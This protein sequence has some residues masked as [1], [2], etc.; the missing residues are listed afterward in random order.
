MNSSLVFAVFML[1]ISPIILVLT[2]I[3]R[4]AGKTPILNFID[5]TSVQNPLELHRRVG[6][7]LILLPV[8]SAVFGAL[9]L[10]M[11]EFAVSTTIV[12]IVLSFGLVW[13]AVLSAQR[14]TDKATKLPSD[15]QS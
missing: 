9:A 15:K 12:F 6:N 13:F 2:L 8:L 14:Y 3:V 1:G 4:F 11:P 10:K 7:I 5:Y